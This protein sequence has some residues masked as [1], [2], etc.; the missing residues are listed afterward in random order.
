VRPVR[1]TDAAWEDLREIG[2]SIRRDSPARAVT[3]TDKLYDLCRDL[4][5]M[6]EAFSLVP[7]YERRGV[8]R[9]VFG[10]YL[11]FFRIEED[12]VRILRILHGARDYA[13]ILFPDEE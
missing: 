10:N 3:F 12:S 2:K 4:G 9:R 6:P 7:R 5:N 1:I 8:R 11:I 13:R